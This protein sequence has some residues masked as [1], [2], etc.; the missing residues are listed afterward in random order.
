MKIKEIDIQNIKANPKNPRQIN[1]E[2]LEKL[3]GSI[4]GFTK[5][6]KIRPIVV[7]EDMMVLGGHQRLAACKELGFKKVWIQQESD[8]TKEE[9]REFSIKDNI[10]SGEWY[11][12]A[13][14]EYFN[15]DDLIEWGVEVVGFDS[16]IDELKENEEIEIPQSVQ[17]EPPKEYIL[18]MAEPNSVDWE[19]I[20]ETLKLKIVRKGG[21]KKGSAFDA[22]GL[23][24]VLFWN[25]FKK[26]YVNSSTK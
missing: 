23:E 26:R 16:K 24:R 21:Y 7:N 19:E 4:T 12:Q 2:K 18:I 1:P 11:E 9:Q 10:S 13:L 20:K 14:Q 15:A 17:L 5:M 8:L 6:M 3:K 25:D 22:V